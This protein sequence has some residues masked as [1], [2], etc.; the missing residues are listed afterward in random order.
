MNIVI[1]TIGRSGSTVLSKMI[2]QLGWNLPN[3]QNDPRDKDG[4]AEHQDIRRLNDWH[5]R[6]KLPFEAATAKAIIESMP[7]PWVVKDPRFVQTWENW[8]P[9]LD[10]GRNC[11]LY[12]SR[13][14]DKIEASLRAKG[15]GH[16]SPKGYMLRGKTTK[17]NVAAC[18]KA[19]NNWSGPKMAFSFERLKAAVKLFDTTRG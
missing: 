8:R 3:A 4:Y 18:W 16:D 17:E 13:S 12:L 2:E 9:L 6:R 1:I 19:Y 7:E 14:P 15:W 11:L 5:L 10:N